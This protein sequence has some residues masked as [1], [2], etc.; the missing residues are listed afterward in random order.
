MQGKDLNELRRHIYSDSTDRHVLRKLLLRVFKPCK[1]R[2]GMEELENW[3]P[4]LTPQETLGDK[5]PSKAV[6]VH[7][8]GHEVAFLTEETVQALD[9]PEENILTLLCYLELHPQHWI[10]VLSPAYVTC[11]VISYSGP[12]ALKV[13]AKKVCLYCTKMSMGQR[14]LNL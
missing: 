3:D 6:P 11:K 14:R 1:C 4:D 2:I 9:L 12:T 5:S 8:P 10:E 13:A 7:C